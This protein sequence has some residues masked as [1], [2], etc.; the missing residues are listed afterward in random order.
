MLSLEQ[1]FDWKQK[2]FYCGRFYLI[3]ERNPEK[4]DS[5]LVE[6]LHPREK[7]PSMRTGNEADNERSVFNRLIKCTDSVQIEARNHDK[8]R[9]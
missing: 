3:D 1:G 8:R 6:T 9:I 4:I 2:S 7:L 5:Q